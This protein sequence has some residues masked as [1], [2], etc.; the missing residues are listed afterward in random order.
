MANSQFILWFAFREI[1]EDIAKANAES[2][3]VEPTVDVDRLVFY[4]CRH[5]FAQHYLC[6]PGSTVNGLASLMARSPN[7]IATYIKQI[8]RDEEIVS[9]IDNMPI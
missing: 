9:S 8:T 2:D 4:T 7:T 1:N 5:S 6:S 3:V